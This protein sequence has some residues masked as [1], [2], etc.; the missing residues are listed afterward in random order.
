MAVGEWSTAAAT[1]G[2][3]EGAQGRAVLWANRGHGVS[4]KIEFWIA[5]GKSRAK[6]RRLQLRFKQ[7]H[8]QECPSLLRASLCYIKRKA[9]LNARRNATQKNHTEIVMSLSSEKCGTAPP[10]Q[11]ANSQGWATQNL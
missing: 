4:P 9:S 5:D 10:L 3:G 7:E 1:V 11:E 8:R 2:K 6:A